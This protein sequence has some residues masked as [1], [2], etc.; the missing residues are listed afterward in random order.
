M[1]E[2]VKVGLVTDALISDVAIDWKTHA[3]DQ[4]R[5]EAVRKGYH[6][7]PGGTVQEI[8]LSSWVNP[9]PEGI[10]T[11]RYAIRLSD[12]DVEDQPPMMIF[13]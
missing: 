9:L 4:L 7:L 1:A 2:Y 11:F 10:R 6:P 12:A 8:E 3:L 5:V 13:D